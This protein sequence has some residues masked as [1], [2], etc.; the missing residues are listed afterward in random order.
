MIYLIIFSI[1]LAIFLFFLAKS[2]GNKIYFAF[3]LFFAVF[4]FL[5]EY[6]NS[7]IEEKQR[8]KILKFDQGYDLIC[9]EI[10]VNN[11]NF[12]YNHGTFSFVSKDNNLSLKSMII[13]LENCEFKNAK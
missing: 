12:T 2:F 13:S 8:F 7:K 3:I 6:I 11:K 1:I 10:I 5:Y 4:I 9:N